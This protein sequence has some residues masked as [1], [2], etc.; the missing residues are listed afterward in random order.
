MKDINDKNFGV[1]I[2]FWLPGFVLLWGLSHSLPDIAVLLSKPNG[3]ICR[4]W[5]TFSTPQSHL[6]PLACL[7][8]QSVG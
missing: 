2:A 3:A 1:I 5:V 6:S 7:S 4:M 8:A